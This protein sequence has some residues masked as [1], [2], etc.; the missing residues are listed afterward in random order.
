MLQYF[1]GM[2]C[3]FSKIVWIGSQQA[4]F[5]FKVEGVFLFSFPSS[6]KTEITS[7]DPKLAQFP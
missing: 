3:L 4:Y 7:F 1:V 5:F 2:F 6:A